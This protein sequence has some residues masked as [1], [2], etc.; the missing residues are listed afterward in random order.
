MSNRPFILK[1]NINLINKP[2]IGKVIINKNV[3]EKSYYIQVLDKSN[4]ILFQHGYLGYIFIN[5]IPENIENQNYAYNILGIDT[6][7][8]YD[9]IELNYDHIKVL[10][11]DDSEDNFIQVTSQCNSNCIMCP[12]S[13]KVRN[14]NFSYDLDRICRIIKCIP[15]DTKNICITGGEPGILKYDLITVLNKCNQYLPNTNFLMLSNGRVFADKKFAEVFSK[16]VPRNFRI[17]IPLYSNDAQI[18]DKITRAKNSFNEAVLGIKNLL[19][20]N[21]QVEIR[22]VIMKKNYKHLEKISAY[23]SEN[24][25]NAAL[26]NFMALEMTGNAYKNKEE[27]WID[28]DTSTKKLYD[29]TLKLLKSGIIAN[30]YNFPLCKLDKRLFTLSKK[31]I[32]DYK[33]RY[34]E[35]CN[36]CNIKEYCGGFFPSTMMFENEV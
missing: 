29:A 4:S 16:N 26:V 17:A 10:Y 25:N 21:I 24:F 8:N 14:T 13:E 35:K 11:R 36:D 5:W 15:D 23:I 28:F 20:L 32:S 7:L 12:D 30:I 33:V 31:S 2:V 9:V 27:V 22:I 34:K 3:D 6:L 18:H 19:A 1:G